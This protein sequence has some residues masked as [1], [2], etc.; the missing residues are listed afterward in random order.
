ML[1]GKYGNAKKNETLLPGFPTLLL[2]SCLL[3]AIIFYNNQDETASH[4]GT[5]KN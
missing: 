1:P 2:C 3:F 5:L 4:G